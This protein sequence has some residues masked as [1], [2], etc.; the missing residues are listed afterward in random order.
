MT[1][2]T[3]GG[4]RP[5][6][7][8]ARASRR[9]GCRSPSP[10]PRSMSWIRRASSAS[11]MPARSRSRSGRV[12]RPRSCGVF[13]N[14]TTPSP[15]TRSPAKSPAS[16][17]LT[18]LLT[19][20]CRGH[21]QRWPRLARE[22]L[23][24][25]AGLEAALEAACSV[26]A[27]SSRRCFAACSAAASFS[28]P[29]WTRRSRNDGEGIGGDCFAP[30]AALPRRAAVAAG[31]GPTCRPEAP[32]VRPRTRRTSPFSVSLASGGDGASN[33]IWRTWG[34]RTADM[35]RFGLRAAVDPCIDRA[36]ATAQR[37]EDRS[38]PPAR[39]RMALEIGGNGRPA[40]PWQ[41]KYRVV[42]SSLAWFARVPRARD[43]VGCRRLP[44]HPPER[45]PR[46]IHL[47]RTETHPHR[48]S[49]RDDDD[50]HEQSAMAAEG[51]EV[52]RVH[53]SRP[54][55]CRATTTGRAQM[56]SCAL[57]LR[58]HRRTGIGTPDLHWVSLD[59]VVAAYR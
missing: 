33:V 44:A 11:L 19:T 49:G 29:C 1:V 24:S 3:T 15:L 53:F 5:R 25:D 14:A 4:A 42:R 39:H 27:A 56:C 37:G 40:R 21:R 7:F 18:E 34:P 12:R 23:G 55:R 48:G 51:L 43:A 32:P 41:R 52:D 22:R 13:A 46:P 2:A 35:T 10:T 17:A 30:R 50:R 8:C 54:E 6:T 26:L 58:V 47:G 57:A 38:R 28:E 16:I 31:T 36:A 20:G 59:S 45:D 9:A